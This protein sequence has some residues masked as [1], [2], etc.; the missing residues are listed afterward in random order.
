[1]K[2]SSHRA[3]ARKEKRSPQIAEWKWITGGVVGLAV[4][5]LLIIACDQ[6]VP[7]KTILALECPAGFDL[8]V[9]DFSLEKPVMIQGFNRGVFFYIEPAENNPAM[10]SALKEKGVWTASPSA[11]NPLLVKVPQENNSSTISSIRPYGRGLVIET[12]GL[13][14]R[15]AVITATLADN[16]Q[17]PL[18]VITTCR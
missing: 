16:N 15:P 2:F 11:D 3:S 14:D 18:H 4:L 7:P 17:A 13:A 8:S 5:T 10:L 6:Q 12:Q 9:N 1:M